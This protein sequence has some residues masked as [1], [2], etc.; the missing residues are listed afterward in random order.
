MGFKKVDSEFTDLSDIT[1]DGKGTFLW[2][3]CFGRGGRPTAERRQIACSRSQTGKEQDQPS[4]PICQFK[5]VSCFHSLFGKI[6]NYYDIIPKA[7]C[8]TQ[9]F[10]TKQPELGCLL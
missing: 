2:Y 8:I 6:L 3:V 10:L 1:L 7:R 9:G 5:I 4:N